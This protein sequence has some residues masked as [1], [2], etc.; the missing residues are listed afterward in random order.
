[1]PS[2]RLAAKFLAAALVVSPALA[3]E[4]PR[5][6]FRASDIAGIRARARDPVLRP[7]AKRLRERAD[8][9]LNAPPLVVSAALRGEPDPSGELKGLEAARRL[10]GRVLTLSMAFTLSG[11]RRYL[12]AAVKELDGALAWATWVDTAHKPPYDL[13]SGELC[14]TFGLAYDWLYAD[15][16]PNQRARLRAGAEKR[17]LG[18]YLDA[19]DRLK[20]LWWL[21]AVNN[22]NVVCNGGAAA[23]ALSLDDESPLSAKV[24]SLALP[25]MTHFWNH[26]TADGGWDEGTGYWTYAM[27]YGLLTAEA[28]RRA[29]N[30]WGDGVFARIGVKR[31]G[32]FPMTFNPGRKL[33]A[34]FGDSNGRA[35]D[36]VFY[37]LGREFQN[38]DFVSFQDRAG[39]PSIKREGWPQEALTILW[40]PIGAPW[41]P[42]ATKNFSPSLPVTMAFADIGWG[43]MAP[44]QP[45]PPYFLA[46]KNGSL[47]A[48]HTHLD[49]NHVSLGYGDTMLLVELGS[50]PYPADYFGP[51]RFAYYELS[52]AGHNTVLIDGAG[53]K[54]GAAGKLLG[55]FSGPG[56]EELIGVADGT[57]ETPAPR[58]RRHVVFMDKV[59]WVLLDEIETSGPHAAE[60]RFHTDGEISVAGPR[61]WT[62]SQ[63]AA[64]L[65]V[66][67]WS[68]ESVEG[69]VEEPTGWIKP[70]KVLSLKA[71]SANEHQ[72]VTVLYPR[73]ADAPK[74]A[75]VSGRASKGRI[76]ITVGGRK[77]TFTRGADGWKTEG[78]GPAR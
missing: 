38:P 15:L 65:D 21:N 26:L 48:N 76:E 30:P 64:A 17:G 73:A 18:A 52:T 19:A 57:Y 25:G 41:L 59:C 14:M 60:L 8:F 42:E 5:L 16:T 74:L 70:V 7:V 63:D 37:L 53:Q 13:M 12:D 23:L 39:L 33:S 27:R 77:I 4:H 9:L 22:W 20:P 47:A 56:F 45:D 3:A 58:A 1:V 6:L 75:P 54:P 50:R 36:P 10:Q 78:V 67:A 11:D 35:V 31:T 61:R 34:G 68:A 71:A 55:P 29:G 51:K 49:L 40:R 66:V 28:L 46:F 32:Y 44:K 69:S 2:L 72:V 62:I 24:L 43:F